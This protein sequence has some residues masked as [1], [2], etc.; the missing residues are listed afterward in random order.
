MKGAVG[1]FDWIRKLPWGD[2]FFDCV[3]L[4]MLVFA[5][6]GFGGAINAAYAMNAMI[7]NTAW[8]QGHF[9][10][11]VGTAVALS[12]MGATYW[13]LPRLSGRELCFKAAAQVQPYLWFIGMMLFAVS[14]HI[15]GIL[16]MP[17]RV[18]AAGYQ[19]SPVAAQWEE[20]T[21]ITAVGGVVLFLSAMFFV[22]VFVGTLLWGKRIE[23][24]PA[25]EYAKPLQ[26][27]GKEKGIWDRMGLWTAVAVILVIVAYAYPILHLI[28]MDRFGSPGFKPF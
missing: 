21:T 13:L 14:N 5:I 16:G 3:V 12:F 19:E 1:W 2:P 20:W 25:V 28:S 18:Y 23:E 9:H 27:L 17:R 26:P 4:S 24:P 10:L 22:L 7:H 6:G 15:T 11:T 8:V